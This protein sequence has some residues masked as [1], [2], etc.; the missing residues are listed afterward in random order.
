MPGFKT[1]NNNPTNVNF[2]GVNTAIS[3][4]YAKRSD[5]R[6][7]PQSGTTSAA[8]SIGNGYKYRNKYEFFHPDVLKP[9]NRMP[10]IPILTVYTNN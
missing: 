6:F 8:H 2:M 9:R 7:M 5:G 10:G 3:F 4:D 1:D